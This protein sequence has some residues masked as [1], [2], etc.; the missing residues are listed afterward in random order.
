MADIPYRLQYI[1]TMQDAGQESQSQEEVEHIKLLA[2]V[3][4]LPDYR[5]E[6]DLDV[7]VVDQDKD[8]VALR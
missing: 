7:A 8:V 2:V 4:R 1:S 6:A 5:V 3:A